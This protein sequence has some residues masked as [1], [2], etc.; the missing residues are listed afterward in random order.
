MAIVILKATTKCNANCAYC[1]AIDPAR[2]G[3]QTMPAEV[4]E[5]FF[6]RANEFLLE[7]PRERLLVIWHGG[8]PLLFGPAFFERALEL[9]QQ[10]CDRTGARLG[11]RLQSN[12]TLFSPRFA[13]IFRKMGIFGIGTSYDPI[14]GLRGL[15]PER[16]AAAYNARFH[17]GLR[18]LE[19]EGFGW[20]LIYVV[21]KLSLERPQEIFRSLCDLKPDGN[22]KLQPVLLCGQ[23]PGELAITPEEFGDFLGAVFPGW[24][25]NREKLPLVEPFR[26]LTGNILEGSR[27]L[28][29]LDSGR[30]A[31]SHLGLAPDGAVSQCGRSLDRGILDYG[32]LSRRSFT[33]ILADPLRETLL[34]R[35]KVLKEG[36]CADCRFWTLCHGGCPL[37]VY[38]GAG[39]FLH[40]SPWCAAKK[41]FLEKYFEPITGVRFQP[42][43][44][45]E[46]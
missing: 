39:S 17:Q 40:K 32:H 8:E 30:C 26:V 13:E 34:R 15:G 44:E 18:L 7:H 6:V 5:L 24:W 43:L 45:Q 38:Q 11:H 4:L 10:I 25:A 46:P 3:V 16:D 36:E 21:T 27:H 19:A 9:Q 2:P 22:F 42:R 20:G 12:L 33:E 29:C 31:A 37:D 28:Y 1:E 14:P 41:G 35:K 23:D